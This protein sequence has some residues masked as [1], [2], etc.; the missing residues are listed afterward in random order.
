MIHQMPCAELAESYANIDDPQ[1]DA[2]KPCIGSET[3]V[4]LRLLLTITA[5]P[6]VCTTRAAHPSPAYVAADFP[7]TKLPKWLPGTQL[8]LTKLLADVPMRIGWHW[9]G[10]SA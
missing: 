8:T 3:S 5:K 9:R 7:W 1:C 4:T 2:S 6:S 10:L